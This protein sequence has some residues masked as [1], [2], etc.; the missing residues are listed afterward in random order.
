M[1]IP[2]L[3]LCCSLALMASC[4]TTRYNPTP[5]TTAKGYAAVETEEMIAYAEKQLG[6]RY[7]YGGKD[8]QGFDCSG[9]TSYVFGNF[10][11][12]LS[13]TADGQAKQGTDIALEEANTGDLI[14]FKR[15]G[16]S[17][18]FHVSLVVSNTSEG[19]VVIHSTTSRG[20]ITENISRSSYWKPF[21]H[22]A[23]RIR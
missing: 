9:F 19:I 17:R 23:R 13:A 11:H 6:T 2:F 8:P 10:G 15:P 20:V 18:I 14:F 21:I 1:K 16:Q 22:H 7:R 5:V 4:S 3:L 12:Q